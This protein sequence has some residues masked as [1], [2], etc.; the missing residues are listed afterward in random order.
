MVTTIAGTTTR[1]SSSRTAADNLSARRRRRGV[2]VADTGAV[3]MTGGAVASACSAADT[4]SGGLAYRSAG[5]LAIA[6][7]TTAYHEDLS[8]ERIAER[9]GIPVGTV[10]TRVFYGLRAL[11]LALEERGFDF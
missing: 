8:R 9:L 4:N 1:A 11:R 2:A 7:A 6:R 10:K 5:D 3:G